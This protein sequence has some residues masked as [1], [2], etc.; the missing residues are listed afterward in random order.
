MARKCSKQSVCGADGGT[1]DRGGGEWR[2]RGNPLRGVPR[3]AQ[4]G[5]P[6]AV[7]RR[8]AS[9]L[10]LLRRPVPSF[11]SSPRIPP[12]F[13]RTPPGRQN[14]ARQFLPPLAPPDP[15]QH[16]LPFSSPTTQAARRPRRQSTAPHHLPAPIRHSRPLRSVALPVQQFE[17][18]VPI[19]CRAQLV[20]PPAARRLPGRAG[21]AGLRPRGPV[22]RRVA[23]EKRLLEPRW[24]CVRSIIRR[25]RPNAQ[26]HRHTAPVPLATACHGHRR[27][28]PQPGRCCSGCA[29][30]GR[31]SGE[32]EESGWGTTGSSATVIK[33]CVHVSSSERAWNRDARLARKQPK[34]QSFK[35]SPS[36]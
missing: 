8:T 34:G 3:L 16:R 10:S 33:P 26:H 5:A 7:K 24:Q 1:V 13:S 29:R 36:V 31:Q 19:R 28:G 35:A 15:L 27:R 21:Q 11:C 9:I 32:F 17:I 22:G 20:H 30:P 12:L 2:R 6:K 23:A 4:S 18:P 14:E 25:E